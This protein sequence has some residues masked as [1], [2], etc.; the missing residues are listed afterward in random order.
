MLEP[1]SGYLWLAALLRDASLCK[2]P[3][4]SL[5]S[6]FNF[7]PCRE[8][9]RTV[10]ELVDEV[11]KHWPGRWEDKSDSQELHEAGLLQLSIDKAHALLGW[12][13]V[14]KFST[15]VEQTV[16]WYRNSANNPDAAS[17]RSMTSEQISLFV[18]VAREL[19]VPWATID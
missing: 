4:K 2:A 12:S 7:G 6:A 18:R 19:G 5:A 17:L 16:N 13:P 9:N 14:W 10:A 8:A 3:A 1:L 11:L 15:A